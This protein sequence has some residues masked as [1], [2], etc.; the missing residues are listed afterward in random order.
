MDLV[1]SCCQWNQNVMSRKEMGEE[2][3]N[4]Q[5]GTRQRTSQHEERIVGVD[6][7]IDEE[8]GLRRR[9]VARHRTQDVYILDRLAYELYR[10]AYVHQAMSES[11]T[12]KRSINNEDSGV[13]THHHQRSNIPRMFS[14]PMREQRDN[15]DYLSKFV[16]VPAAG[17]DY[18][19]VL[20]AMSVMKMKMKLVQNLLQNPLCS[21]MMIRSQMFCREKETLC[22]V[23][24][25]TAGADGYGGNIVDD[26]ADGDGHDGSGDSHEGTWKARRVPVAEKRCMVKWGDGR[27]A[28]AFPSRMEVIRTTETMMPLTSPS[29]PFFLIVPFFLL[30]YF[31]RLK[32]LGCFPM[33][34]S[35]ATFWT[36]ILKLKSVN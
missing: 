13:T 36:A 1:S 31:S 35:C 33:R 26:G 34:N 8:H 25:S 4:R 6:K 3:S 23:D 12:D 16:A 28:Y 7:Y 20:R 22:C 19:I 30:F 9:H 32:F 15:E 14:R 27:R 24:T 18:H 5:Q 2:P 11:M 29:F 17:V 10:I 21:M